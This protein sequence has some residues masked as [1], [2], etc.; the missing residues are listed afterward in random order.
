M[1]ISTRGFFGEHSEVVGNLF[2]LSN[3]ATLGACE[4]E[5]LQHTR[6]IISDVITHER[7]ARERILSDAPMELSDKIYRSWGILLHAKMLSMTEFLNLTS[8][9]RLG[10]DCG[11]FKEL[12][13]EQLHR[14]TIAVMPAHM[15][16]IHKKTMSKEQRHCTRAI[17]V[18]ELMGA[19]S[20]KKKRKSAKSTQSI[21]QK[22][23][24]QHHKSR[25]DTKS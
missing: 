4:D 18:R 15:Q 10:I 20:P 23:D 19:Q 25:G 1:G 21:K 24:M 5:F 16:H 8:A 14:T 6:K 11:I 22:N 12:T 3:Q 9:L 17:M 13:T 7:T 2:Q